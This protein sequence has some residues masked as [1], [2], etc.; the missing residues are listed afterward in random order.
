[1]LNLFN[2][3][4]L[5]KHFY[6]AKYIPSVVQPFK[7]KLDCNLTTINNK[8]IQYEIIAKDNSGATKIVPLTT[9]KIFYPIFKP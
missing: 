9:I 5:N 2:F 4:K 7:T 6:I 8:N 3:S 1:M